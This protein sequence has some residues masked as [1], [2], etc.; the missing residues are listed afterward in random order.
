MER[1]RS[2][3]RERGRKKSGDGSG[4]VCEGR[5]VEKWESK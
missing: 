2:E 4:I 1:G 3:K 5:E